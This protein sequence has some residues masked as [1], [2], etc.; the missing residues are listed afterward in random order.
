MSQLCVLVDRN[1]DAHI[2]I[3]NMQLLAPDATPMAQ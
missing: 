2:L 1:G 3:G